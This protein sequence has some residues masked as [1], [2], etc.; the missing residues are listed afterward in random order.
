LFAVKESKAGE[1]YDGSWLFPV[2]RLDAD[3]TGLLLFTNSTRLA[4]L[5]SAPEA[6]VPKTYRALVGGRLSGLELERLKR[7]VAIREKG[8]TLV[9]R[10]AVAATQ[11]PRGVNTLVTLDFWRGN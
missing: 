1:R 11:T 10:P 7:G 6:K 3:T 2:G 9:T 5:L 8:K 4:A